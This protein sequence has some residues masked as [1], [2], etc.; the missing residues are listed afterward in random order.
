MVRTVPNGRQ[1]PNHPSTDVLTHSHQ[2][3]IMHHSNKTQ[4]LLQQSKHW[5]STDSKTKSLS[6]PGYIGINHNRYFKYNIFQTD[7]TRGETFDHDAQWQAKSNTDQRHKH[8][9]PTFKLQDLGKMQVDLN[10]SNVIKKRWL[11]PQWCIEVIALKR[12]F[13][14]LL[15]VGVCLILPQNALAVRNVPFSLLC[16]VLL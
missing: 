6:L 3:Q 5:K 9:K 11:F 16:E 12:W 10:W 15:N 13:Y 7:E 2:G 14:K 1:W 4:Y 8:L